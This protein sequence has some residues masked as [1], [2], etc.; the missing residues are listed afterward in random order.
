LFQGMFDSN[1]LTFNLGWD[2]NAQ[3]IGAFTDVRKLQRQLKVCGIDIITEADESST[4]PARCMIADPDG[5]P[6]R[7]DQ[8][9]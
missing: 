3:P 2:N 7:V 8:H 5:N 9:L 6:I 4:G 1:I